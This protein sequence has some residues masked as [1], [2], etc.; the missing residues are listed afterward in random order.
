MV[1]G[2]ACKT[3]RE[4]AR[5]TFKSSAMRMVLRFVQV[6]VMIVEISVVMRGEVPGGDVLWN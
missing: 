6:T 3:E 1:P 4:T 5:K 2:V